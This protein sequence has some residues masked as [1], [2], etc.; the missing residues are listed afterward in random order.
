MLSR[1]EEC[2]ISRNAYIP[3]HIYPYVLLIS[4]LEPF[5]Y[6]PFLFYEKDDQVV[7]IGYP[8]EG[9]FDPEL[10]LK[11]IGKLKKEK[12]FKKV[13]A[14]S[15][16]KIDE[17]D[18]IDSDFYYLLDLKEVKVSQ[19]TKNMLKRA[20]KEVKI[21]VEKKLTSEHLRL[22][23]EFLSERNLGEKTSSIFR[24]M[25]A[26][27]D[28]SPYAHVISARNGKGDLLAFNIFDTFSS[29]FSFYM[30]NVRSRRNY[31]PGTS[32]LL[33]EEM[34]RMAFENGKNFINLGLGINEGVRFFKEKW[35]GKRFL[36]Y[37]YYEWVPKRKL[38]DLIFQ[39]FL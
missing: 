6:D 15:P 14:I 4:G 23:E 10:F 33:F 32:D 27:V 11:L 7:L 8:L 39:G 21:E 36:A 30:F 34:I 17:L 37:Y 20:K 1:E 2:L 38:T 29:S 22:L 28:S 26:Y 19:K 35:G 3:E 16:S 31:I 25:P 12:G 13:S 5:Y 24:R 18:P 9:E